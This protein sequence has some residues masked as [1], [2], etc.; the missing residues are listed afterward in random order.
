MLYTLKTQ[1]MQELQ[2]HYVTL[3]L[4]NLVEKPLAALEH[5]LFDRHLEQ[6]SIEK[7]IFIV[8]SHR[9]GTT[10]LYEALAKHPDLA[11]F[12]NSSAYLPKSPMLAHMIGTALS[13]DQLT[14]ERFLKD[15][16]GFN[17]TTPSEGTRIWEL[18]APN[19]DHYCLDETYNN[20]EMERYLQQ[21]IR[22]HLKY[23]K[24]QRFINKNPDSSV[25]MRYLNKLFPDA[26]F[27]HIIRDG[28]A[29]C[30]SMMKSQ[31]LAIEFFGADHRN[32]YGVKTRNSK[33]LLKLLAVD[34]LAAIGKSWCDVI[35]TIDRDRQFIAPERYLEI[36]YEDFVQQPF[37]Y[38][39]KISKF[40]NLSLDHVTHHIFQQE[41]QK[42]DLGTRN[43][44]WKQKLS[45]EDLQ[46]LL[47][48]IEPIMKKHGYAIADELAIDHIEATAIAA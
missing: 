22:K 31:D 25:R 20:P 41:A 39:C 5:W 47:P 1:I 27:I 6:I 45:T 29:V 21:T 3:E 43:E 19:T 36:R 9:S 18:H 13:Q 12:S 26:Y 48:I 16:I 46:R 34:R 44:A 7:P 40:C 38:L 17:A 4:P 28:R 33:K 32:V 23:L 8:G 10:V 15:G 35:E 14:L 2:R 11:Y 24:G 30:H 37:D 42:L